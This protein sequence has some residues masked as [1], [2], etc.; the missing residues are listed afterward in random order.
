M[1]EIPIFASEEGTSLNAYF[2][3]AGVNVELAFHNMPVEDVERI[4][5]FLAAD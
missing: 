3:Q 5:T 4:I 1:P 2:E